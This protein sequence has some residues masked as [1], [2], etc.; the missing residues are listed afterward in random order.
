MWPVVPASTPLPQAY[1]LQEL[2]QYYVVRCIAPS[3]PEV[4]DGYYSAFVS[5][6][7]IVPKY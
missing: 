5:L 1:P 7:G 2:V 4:L 3:S 6:E